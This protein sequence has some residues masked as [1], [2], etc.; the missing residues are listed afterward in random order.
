MTSEHYSFEN[1]NTS[2]PQFMIYYYHLL[3][4]ALSSSNL[5]STNGHDGL[6]ENPNTGTIGS[7]HEDS[8]K[9]EAS[10]TIALAY[11]PVGC[12]QMQRLIN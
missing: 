12:M 6:M 8:G 2:H 3:A 1:A 11:S 5:V 9:L 10:T 4:M 7:E